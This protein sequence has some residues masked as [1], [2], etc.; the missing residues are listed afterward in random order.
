MNSDQVVVTQRLLPHWKL[1]LTAVSFRRLI[2]Y[3]YHMLLLP[4]KSIK[5]SGRGE[6]RE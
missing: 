4:L 5:Q 1:Y 6:W 2:S 3:C